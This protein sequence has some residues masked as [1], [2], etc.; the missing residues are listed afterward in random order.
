LKFIF[1]QKRDVLSGEEKYSTHHGEF[2]TREIRVGP[3][4]FCGTE[5]L[6]NFL[7]EGEGKG[8]QLFNFLK[9]RLLTKTVVVLVVKDA[10]VII[11]HTIGKTLNWEHGCVEVA[12]GSAPVPCILLLSGRD[13]AALACGL[14]ANGCQIEYAWLRL[15]YCSRAACCEAGLLERSWGNGSSGVFRPHHKGLSG[16]FL[17]PRLTRRSGFQP[18]GVVTAEGC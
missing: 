6:R 1:S 11:R 4:T 14:E 5:H 18:R 15:G 2:D 10:I 16:A 13:A 17:L 3:A 12:L 9:N 8:T 7:K